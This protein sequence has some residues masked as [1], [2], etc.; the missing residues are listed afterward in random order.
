MIVYLKNDEIDRER[1]DDCIRNSGEN[2]PYSFSW[3]LDAIAPG[4][5]ALVDD[6]YDS[7]FP[8]PSYIRF[9]LQY[10]CTPPFLQQL[11]AYSPDKPAD[12][13]II[14]FLDYMPDIY[15]LTDLCI[16]QNISYPGYK[17]TEID[18]FELKLSASYDKLHDRFTRDC[19]RYI[20]ESSRKKYELDSHVS[21]EELVDLCITN[22]VINVKGVKIQT[23]ERLLNLMHYCLY[24]KK[25][26]IVALRNARKKLIYGIFMVKLQHSLTIVLEATTPA[27]ITRHVGYFVMNEIIKEYAET[28]FILDFAGIP[29]RLAVSM[30]QLFGGTSVPYYRIYRNRLFWPS[31]LMK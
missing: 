18:N 2:K 4:W 24:N 5:E 8:I 16:R 28:P 6:D 13:V 21:P 27:A 12:D 22:R 20:N 31:R 11:G 30:G 15:K 1:W 3:Y 23:Y 19:R 10:A 25:G 7:V 26:K 9:G 29:D 14:E 17:V